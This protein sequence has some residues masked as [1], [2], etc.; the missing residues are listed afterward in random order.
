[1]ISVSD[2]KASAALPAFAITVASSNTPPT[3][4][5]TPPTTAT[6][7]T[8]Y[9][10]T[11]TANDADAGT[12]LTFSVA[13]KPSWATFSTATGQLQGTP[14]ASG[15]F[16]NVTIGV[17][18]G[19][20]DAQL[21]P[22]TIT[23]SA[24]PNRAP[25]ITGTPPT[26]VTQ[27]AAYSFTPSASDADNDTLTFSITNKPSWAAFNTATGTLTGT[28]GAANVGTTTGI[29]I[30]V[31]DG[32][33]TASLSAFAI[34]VSAA[35]NHAPVISGTPSTSVTVGAAYSF[36]PTASDADNDALT[37]S[38]ANKPSWAAFNTGTGALN[39]TPTTANVGANTGIV[40]SV[41]DGK[42]STPLAAFAITVNAAP[43]HAPAIS[44]TPSTS[45]TVGTAYS[46]TPIASDAD[47]DTLTFSI[48]K[49]PSWAQFSAATGALTGT[50]AAANV[51]TTT[52]IVITVNDGKTSTSLSAFSVTVNAAPNHAPVISGTPATSVTAGTAYSFTPT[53]SDADNDALTFSIANKPSWATFST[54]TGALTGTPAAANVGTTSG[55]V[56]SASDGKDSTPLGAFA[57]TVNAAPNHAPVISGTPSTSVTAGTAYSFTPVRERRR[58][59]HAHVLDRQ[60]AIVG[61]VQYLHG[62]SDRHAGHGERRQLRPESRSA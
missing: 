35:L 9:T 13:N 25:V 50:P 33:A 24:G 11:P 49:K 1:M 15:T 59:R 57:I 47:N 5:G 20:D 48:S 21:A 54:A 19:Q 16:A 40:I 60:Q 8:Q 52:G 14:S 29:V 41:S 31:N 56:I 26:S 34:T 44:G 32:K 18:D 36:T 42:D 28:P 37:F 62:R 27:G 61:D 3:I 45:V 23:V 6:A 22:F 58:P 43:N 17:S 55:I 53:A 7:G 51:G 12:T 39:G 46:F 4:S 30:T 2:G 38:I 10:F